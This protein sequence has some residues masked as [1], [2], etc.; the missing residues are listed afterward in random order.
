MRCKVTRPSVD[1]RSFPHASATLCCPP[2]S[3]PIEAGPSKPSLS[4]DCSPRCASLRKSDPQG[5]P[6]NV[7]SSARAPSSTRLDQPTSDSSTHPCTQAT[8]ARTPGG[9]LGSTDCTAQSV[10]PY[11]KQGELD[12]GQRPPLRVAACVWITPYFRRIPAF[13]PLAFVASVHLALHM[14]VGEQQLFFFVPLE[15]TRSS[16]PVK[17]SPS[18]PIATAMS[19]YA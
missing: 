16:K 3:S 11:R 9:P 4:H 15:D 17:S 14:Q 5:S 13:E 2:A 10:L 8:R 18:P 12:Q 1:R 7:A 19:I 6:S